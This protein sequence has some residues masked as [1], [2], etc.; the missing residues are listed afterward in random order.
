MVTTPM[1][2]ATRP[3]AMLVMVSGDKAVDEGGE[4]AA[5]VELGDIDMMKVE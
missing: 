4:A 2:E 1:M 3:K 5:R